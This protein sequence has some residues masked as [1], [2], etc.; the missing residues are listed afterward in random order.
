MKNKKDINLKELEKKAYKSTF[1]D[2]LWD[3][4]LGMI[5]LGFSLTFIEFNSESELLLKYFLIIAPWNLVAVLILILGKRYITIPRLG[6]VEFG[7]K[8]QKVEQKLRFFVIINIIVFALL[9][10]LPLSGILGDLSL[11]NY[12]TAL[13][14]GFL[15]IWLPLSIVAF[16]LRFSRLYIYAI[17]GGISFYLTE[18]LYPLFGEPYDTILSFGF[19]G[20]IIISIGIILFIKF[21]QRYPKVKRSN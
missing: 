9:L 6:Y 7:P 18:I 13:L 21:I 12:S 11:G 20:G 8:R 2:G 1:Q 4:F 19:I 17:M 10:V 16:I 14:I 3:I 5:F 15:V